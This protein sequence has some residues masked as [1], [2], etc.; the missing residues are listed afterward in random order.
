[1]DLKELLTKH[2]F[3]QS[4]IDVLTASGITTLHPPQAEAIRNR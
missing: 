4:F 1:M 3:P 2:A